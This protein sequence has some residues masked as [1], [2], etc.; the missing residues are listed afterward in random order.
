MGI[1]NIVEPTRAIRL[2]RAHYPSWGSGTPCLHE[3]VLRTQ[4]SLPLMG[5]RNQAVSRPSLQPR[6]LTTP[7]GDQEPRYSWCSRPC[8]TAHYPSW[9][10][11][12]RTA[13]SPG[14]RGTHLTTPHGDQELGRALGVSRHGQVLT[15]LMGIRNKTRGL[16]EAII[17]ISLPL[18]GIRNPH[19]GGVA[20]GA[21]IISL[22]LMGIRNPGSTVSS[23]AWMPSSL[24]LMGIRNSTSAPTAATRSSSHYP[25]WGSGTAADPLTSAV[26]T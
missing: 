25:S 9:G 14:H 20:E 3:T 24:P 18:M 26:R 23:A 5:I 21:G 4:S 2:L 1:R 11:G 7:H 12:T 16:I 13:S 8:G 19:P 6:D 10:S 15:T 17:L 22:P